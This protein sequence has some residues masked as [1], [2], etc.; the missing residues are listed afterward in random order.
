MKFFISLYC[1]LIIICSGF[2]Q[3]EKSSFLELNISGVTFNKKTN[4]IFEDHLGFL[5]LCTN[6]GLYRYDGHNLEENVLNV[7][8]KNSLPNNNVNSVIEDNYGNLWLGSESYLILYNRKKNAFNGFYKDKSSKILGKSADGTIWA[9][10]QKVGIVRVIPNE[11]PE[12]V[13][14]D[15]SINYKKS[16]EVLSNYNNQI[17]HY[18]EDK[19]NRNWFATSKGIFVLDDAMDK[20][21]TNFNIN[22]LALQ[23]GPN[24]TI[25]AATKNG[26]Y[27][28]KYTQENY[29]LE[30][31]ETYT[32]KDFPENINWNQ[33]IQSLTAEP[34]GDIIW[35][36]TN[37]GLLKG[38]R[39]TQ[40]YQFS[41][42]KVNSGDNKSLNNQIN[43]TLIDRYNN[44]WVGSQKGLS[45]LIGKSNIFE[46]ITLSNELNNIFASS[47]YPEGGDQ[48]LVG[49]RKK[50]IYRYNISNKSQ[51]SFLK[52][53]KEVNFLKFDD[54][55]KELFV[56]LGNKLI[57]TKNYKPNKLTHTIDT[58]KEYNNPVKNI[59]IL[60]N[61]CIWVG[62]WGNGIDI[63][64]SNNEISLFEKKVVSTLSNDNI[65]V[66]HLDRNK[67][68]WIG[69]RGSGLYKINLTSEKIKH[70]TPEQNGGISSNAILCIKET[71]DGKICIGTRGG[72][73]NIY[74][75]NKGQQIKVY[76]KE[77]GLLSEIIC[78]IEEDN[79]GNLWFSTLEG[80]S[81]LDIKTEKI[82]NFGVDEGVKESQFTFNSYNANNEHLYFGCI[83]GF[84][85]VNPK[86]FKKT[87]LI[88][89]TVITDFSIFGNEINDT[90]TY[91]NNSIKSKLRFNK[92]IDLPYNQNN[93][94]IKFS[95]LD[96]TSP[97][98]NKY[99]YMLEGVND[100]WLYTDATNRNANYNNLPPGDYTFKVKSTNSDGVWNNVPKQLYFTISPPFWKSNTAIIIY[101][102]LAFFC[103]WLSLLLINN[104][105]KLK[106]NL[107]AE[108]VSREKD[109]EHH[110]MKMTFFT[111]ISHELRTPLSLILGTVEKVVKE[112][113]FTLSPLTSQ[114]IYNNTLRMHRLINQI[115]DIRKFDEGKLKLNISK[116]NIIK[117]I[118]IIKNT[119]NDFA[120]I[121]EIKY[122]FITKEREIKGWYDVDILEKILFNL[123]SNAF[124][125]TK[126]KGEISLKVELLTDKSKDIELTRLAKGKY[127]KCVVKDNG[128]GIPKKD[129]NLIFDR[130]YQATKTYSNQIPGTG[131]G[132]E[133]VQKLVERHHGIIMVESEENVFTEFTFYLPI[134]KN[135]YHKKEILEKGEPLKKSFIKNSEYQVIEEVNSEFESN[136]K[137]ISK[138]KVLIVEDNSDLRLML[139]EELS[140]TFQIIEAQNGKEGYETI[141]KEK[142]QLII[143]D[144][145]MP[146]EDG[147]SMLKRIKKN[148]DINNIPIFMLTAKNSNETKIE[149]VSLGADD[150]IEK[151][152]SL[153][154]VKWK[155]KNTLITRKILKE[156]F[157][158]VITSKPS[159]IEIESNEEKFIKKLIKIIENSMDDNLLSVEFLASEVGMSRA[160]LYRKLQVIIND[161]PV[162]FIK[163]IKLKRAVQLL[164][165]SDMY[166]SEIAYM[167]GFNNQ[168][169][170]SKCFSKEYNMSPT[171]YIKNYAKKDK[172]IDI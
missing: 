141:L 34:L 70:F 28:L 82:K 159:E 89:N 32:S 140:D 161:T 55:S 8:D 104:W 53:T 3:S 52:T 122:D 24:N 4:Y 26:V 158:K 73:L 143:S 164:E 119:F 139:V 101:F 19:Y 15:S 169:Y 77:N 105:Y 69:T 100:F 109:K 125:Y 171:Q 126:E 88:P 146:I 84:Y 74:N 11:N 108:T 71:K 91:N 14:L 92:V 76:N 166:I 43:T 50:G 17:N 97:S 63:I 155:V 99:A 64:K 160:N 48:I 31:L 13:T 45:K 115:M 5:W 21:N 35:I 41:L 103:I 78:S 81:F 25:I 170:F 42:F 156:K 46:N 90:L 106:K 117:D 145:L 68:I 47:L 124:K 131:I 87:T 39:K 114:R 135:R 102:V 51:Q 37:Y 85:T 136:Q 93:I 79:K 134:S 62:L 128:V 56:G 127:I 75:E 29:D 121:Y 153:E 116:N 60:N 9:F 27:V 123:L 86:K 132:M 72:G 30:I 12:N 6:N 111:D 59:T 107:V 20:K 58:L 149:C 151:P 54:Y 144:I 152:F 120:K 67:N 40:T 1:F 7:F 65:Y 10:V 154:F 137:N 129:L 61:N 16:T 95:S 110:R 162:N 147:I 49:F 172:H 23:E 142:P 113:K 112:K 163:K 83:G 167:T 150:Y 138:P 165:N 33:S 80:I 96:F 94:V 38:V 36:G 44:L 22:T 133:L 66:M 148:M 130:Y 157:S 168:K 98:K 118:S 57:R 18:F 2:S